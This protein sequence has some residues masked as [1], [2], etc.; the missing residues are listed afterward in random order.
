MIKTRFAPSPTGFLHLGGARTALFSWLFARKMGGTFVLRIEDT[1]QERST[2]TSVQAILDAMHW[3]KLDYEEGPYYQTKRFDRYSEVIHQLIK[4]DS[5][6]Y[7]CCSKQRLESLRA[8]QMAAKEKPRYDGCC[9]ELNLK[10]GS[11]SELVVRFKNPQ[12]GVVKFYDHVK[13]DISVS[14]AE[15]DDLIIARSDG[16]PTYN[17]TVVVDDMDMQIT[18]V[19]RGDDHVNNTPRQINILKALGAECPEYAHLPMILGDDG[20]RLSKRHG[21]VGV[22]QYFEDGYLAE[23]LLNYLVRLGW[24]H[25]DQE[26]FSIS[27]M[28]EYFSLDDIN[29]SASIFNSEKLKWLNAQYLISQPVEQI[30]ALVKQ[31]LQKIG[32]DFDDQTDFHSIVDLYRQ[33][34]STINE[35][36]DDILYCFCD[37]DE[38]DEKAAKKTLRPVALEPLKKLHGELAQLDDWNST[39]IHNVIEAITKA[40]DVKMG[41]V[42][43]PLRVAITGGSFSPPIDKTVEIIGRAR[44]LTRINNAISYIMEQ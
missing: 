2:E 24:S 41:A 4:Q 22:M 37:F 10:P 39:T 20:K 19:V 44:T 35:L 42:G 11:D 30:I 26:L 15:L 5:A 9:R 28:I 7:C 14:N 12:Q 36:T 21:A 38:Y 6:Y 16:T 29:K 40:L 27:E 18:H 31:R 17:L 33:R 25:G 3:L 32:V 1:D 34:V 8:T 23:A 43:Q 13:G